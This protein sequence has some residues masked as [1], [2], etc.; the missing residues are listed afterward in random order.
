MKKIR[1]FK[2]QILINLR[3][4]KWLV[5]IVLM[6]IVP[7]WILLTPIINKAE[8]PPNSATFDG[9][10]GKIF[11]YPKGDIKSRRKP[12]KYSKLTSSDILFV[13]GTS[14]GSSFKS[15][16]HLKLLAG[17]TPVS[18]VVQ[19]G[20]DDTDTLLTLFLADQFLVLV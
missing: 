9:T 18:P 20:T 3:H 17:S 1:G 12:K 6:V 16:A 8:I 10:K 14:P 19:A 5:Y 15:W 2:Q 4:S 13:A 11:V 7:I